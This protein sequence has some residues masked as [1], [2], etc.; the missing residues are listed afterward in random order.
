VAREVLA[1]G[2]SH[3]AWATGQHEEPQGT[4]QAAR[5]EKGRKG[6]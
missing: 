3:G 1:G 5:L 4:P 2:E 6:W